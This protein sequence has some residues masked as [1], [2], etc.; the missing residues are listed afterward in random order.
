MFSYDPVGN[1]ERRPY[2]CGGSAQSLIQPFL[3]NQ[4]GGNHLNGLVE[5]SIEETKRIVMDA[6]TSAT[7]RDIYTGD[8]VEIFT[9]TRQGVV[10]EIFP[11]KRD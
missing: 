9:V 5:Y 4:V 6:F 3:D 8:N 11:L 2:N 1:Y 10:K 7:E